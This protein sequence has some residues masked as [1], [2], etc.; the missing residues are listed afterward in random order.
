M[1]MQGRELLAASQALRSAFTLD[2]FDQLLLF[3]LD[4]RRENIAGPENFQTIVYKGLS[5]AER[6]GWTSRL[7]AVAREAN[8]TNADL[9]AL[10]EKWQL[11]PLRA[12]AGEALERI[13]SDEAGFLDIT[14]WRER[15][16]GLEG[17][18]GRVEIPVPGG[19]MKGT[20]FLVAPNACLTNYHVVQPVIKGAVEPSNVVVRFDYKRSADG[21]I[22][23]DGTEHRLSDSDWLVD[24]SPPSLGFS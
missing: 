14:A 20:A 2:E 17:T 18:V 19:I 23:N 8:P 7:L 4:K 13:L 15:L 3:Y 22:L 6:E 16:G 9:M 21:V 1:A 11:A 24:A 10:A 12:E 5:A